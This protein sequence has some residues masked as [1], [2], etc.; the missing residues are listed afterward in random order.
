[1]SQTGTSCLPDGGA[2]KCQSGQSHVVLFLF[3]LLGWIMGDYEY[4][5]ALLGL[6]P[7]QEHEMV[8]TLFDEEDRR[9]KLE[10]EEIRLEAG[11]VIHMIWLT[12]DLPASFVKG[13][14]NF[15]L[16]CDLHFDGY[17]HLRS[18][19]TDAPGSWFVE[20]G[21]EVRSKRVPGL[22]LQCVFGSS[23]PSEL[24]KHEIVEY[25]RS[26]AKVD[27]DESML[28]D[29]HCVVSAA[30]GVERHSPDQPG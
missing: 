16:P 25:L 12:T 5:K 27:V 29:G 28:P 14:F 8:E 6:P 9:Q 7:G 2:I 20:Q 4:M 21:L 30:N 22:W 18:V 1:M 15:R 26:V 24:F 19:S 17:N 13:E 11:R 3:K 23:K 10:N